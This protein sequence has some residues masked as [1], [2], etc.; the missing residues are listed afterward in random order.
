MKKS[1]KCPKLLGGCGSFCIEIRQL[2][3][4]KE[5]SDDAHYKR[6]YREYRYL[7][8]KCKKEWTQETRPDLHNQICRV[9]NNSQYKC[10]LKNKKL[11]CKLN[12]KNK[13]YKRY[14]AY[15]ERTKQTT[16]Q[17]LYRKY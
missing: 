12:P 11:I 13:Q 14:K 7:C 2:G 9:P 3:Y 5:M 17:H 4:P 16:T 10:K 15:E 6:I 8:P 1:I